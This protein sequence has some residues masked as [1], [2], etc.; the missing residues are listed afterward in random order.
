MIKRKLKNKYFKRNEF[1][2]VGCS[3]AEPEP[4]GAVLT[5]IKGACQPVPKKGHWRK[6][7]NWQR[8]ERVFHGKN[9]GL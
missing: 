8:E 5:L 1:F 2:L 9:A 7:Y 6:K 4:V 3:V